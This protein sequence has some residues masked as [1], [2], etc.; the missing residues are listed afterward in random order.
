MHDAR[1]VKFC[2]RLSK[3]LTS[4]SSVTQSLWPAY[5]R[6]APGPLWVF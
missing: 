6:V 3:N 5:M 1:G 4:R 2:I